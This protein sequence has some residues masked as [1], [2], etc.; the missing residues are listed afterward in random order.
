MIALKATSSHQGIFIVEQLST[1][2]DHAF[3]DWRPIYLAPLN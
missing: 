3:H 1:F 2:G